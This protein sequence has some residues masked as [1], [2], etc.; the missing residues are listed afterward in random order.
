MNKEIK[1]S[2][3]GRYVETFLNG[4][5]HSFN[6]EPAVHDTHEGNKSW[7]KNGILHRD[8]DKPAEVCFKHCGT[9]GNDRA[10]FHSWYN[11]SLLIV[12]L[13]IISYFNGSDKDST[14]IFKDFSIIF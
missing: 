6:D 11:N 8:N 2:D 4:K 10:E 13:S 12:Y 5:L 7:Y 9:M 3:F 14:F 1:T